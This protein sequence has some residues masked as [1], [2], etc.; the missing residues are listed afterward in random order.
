MCHT[1][2]TLMSACL[3]LLTGATRAFPQA[4]TLTEH[5]VVIPERGE[6]PGYMVTLE[7]NRF[8][9]LPPPGWRVSCKPGAKCVV[10]I[11]ADLTSSI[12]VD[13]PEA[14]VSE[15]DV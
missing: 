1:S 8:A 7:T 11:S 10:I 2:A 5:R 6:V 3:L 9:F 12:T 14:E 4:A 13:F 15:K